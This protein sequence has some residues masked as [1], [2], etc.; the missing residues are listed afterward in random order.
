MWASGYINVWRLIHRIDEA[1]IEIIPTEEVIRDAL[2]DEMS[3][4]GSKLDNRDDL[5]NNL[6]LA[7]KTF[8]EQAAVYLH[9]QPPEQGSSAD[10]VHRL[11]GGLKTGRVDQQ[12]QHQSGNQGNH[13]KK[14]VTPFE[15]QARARAIIR[16]VRFSLHQFR[17][18]RW[19]KLIRVRNHL[20]RTTFLT[21]LALYLLAAFAII[22]P[23]ELSPVLEAATIFYLVGGIVSLF[24]RLYDQSKTDSSIDDFR[25]AT[26]RLMAAPVFSG[27]AAVGGV[28]IVMKLTI[29][30]GSDK[31][32]LNLANIIVAAVFGLTPSLFV[33]T[34]QKQADQ[35]KADLKSTQAPTGEQEK[36]LS[37]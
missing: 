9:Q 5:L 1:L 20:M 30:P 22:L 28:L 19:E 2:H 32:E 16:E 35:Y 24:G 18:D 6:R 15:S 14:P 34:F 4:I 27:L 8:D 11:P 29:T 23:Q 21:G 3:I 13:K 33:T 26:A 12:S 37:T 17:D 25:L 10:H 36:V 7:V 31:F